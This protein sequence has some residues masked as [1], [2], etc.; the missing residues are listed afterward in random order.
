MA[1]R[2]APSTRRRWRRLLSWALASLLAIGTLPLT[3]PTAPVA[4]AA[5]D[6]ARGRPVFFDAPCP[7]PFF[8]LSNLVDGDDSTATQICDMGGAANHWIAVDLGGTYSITAFRWKDSGTGCWAT[9]PALIGSDDRNDR[10]IHPVPGDQVWTYNGDIND[11]GVVNLATVAAHRFWYLYKYGPDTQPAGCRFIGASFEL[12]GTKAP[13]PNVDVARGRPVFMDPQCTGPYFPLA[14]LVDG[15]DSTAT[16]I[17]DMGGAA[18]H[19]LAVDLGGTY[20]ITSFRWKDSGASCWATHPAL[21]G[22]DYQSPSAHPVPG[23]QVWSYN[24]DIN[25]TGV[26]T[27]ATV[28]AHRYWYLYKYGPDTQPA[29]CRFIGASFELYGAPPADPLAQS[30]LA[31][32][33]PVF[34]DPQCA[35]PFFQLAYLVDRD[36]STATQICNTA[37]SANHWIAVDLGATYSVNAFRWKDGGPGWFATHPALIGS[38]DT[39]PTNAHPVVGDQVWSYNG[40]INDT[41]V[42]NLATVTAHRYWYLYKYGP[43]TQPPLCRFLGGSFELYGAQSAPDAGTPAPYTFGAQATAAFSPDP[44]NLATGSFTAHADDLSLPGRVVGFSFTRWYNSADNTPGS[45]LGAG[46]THSYNWKLSD[47]GATAALRRGDGRQDT[48]TK[49]PD[50]TYAPPPGVFDVLT[51]NADATFTLTL[52]SQVRYDFSSAGQLTRISEPAGNQLALSYSGGNLP[53]SPIASGVG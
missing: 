41:G 28:A 45:A 42:V 40:D 43:D 52:P 30:D 4:E 36:D 26:V 3:A 14:N 13:E 48:F 20:A 15:D 39:N 17:C 23:D 46:W 37:D 7:G 49:N 5:S 22:S 50:G 18:N 33:R 25:D 10:N 21:I 47:A 24:G 16:Q 38:D 35:G 53:R 27:L 19:W 12:Y 11:T 34:F 2:S 8:P 1:D 51:K 44:V 31:R 6:L 29:G 32:S 9:H